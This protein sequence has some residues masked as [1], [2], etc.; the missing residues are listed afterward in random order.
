MFASRRRLCRIWLIALPVL[1]LLALSFTRGHDTFDID[2]GETQRWYA[3][4]P[5]GVKY[6][7]H[8]G[9]DPKYGV[10]LQPV[11]KDNITELE[12]QVQGGMRRVDDGK[13]K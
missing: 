6:F 8:G 4:T 13:N 12:M 3:R 5:E 11:T 7:N 9:W 1:Y 10:E 2:G